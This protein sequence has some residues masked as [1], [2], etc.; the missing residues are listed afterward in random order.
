MNRDAQFYDDKL[1]E[2]L[3][4]LEPNQVSEVFEGTDGN[5]YIARVTDVA[6]DREHR[7]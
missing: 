4:T 7:L 5:Y 2:T 1:V 3:F 6:P